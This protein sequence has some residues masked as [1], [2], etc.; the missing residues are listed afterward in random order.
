M[1]IT[2]KS[3]SVLLLAFLSICGRAQ[4][5]VMKAIVLIN[6]DAFLVDVL[7]NGDITT[8]YQEVKNYFKSGES[9]ESMMRRLVPGA[10]SKEGNLVF[11]EK[12]AEPVPSFTKENKRKIVTGNQQYIGFSP[13]KALLLK[14]AVDQIRKI[15]EAYTSSSIQVI[16]ISSY[17]DNSYRTK[18]LARNRAKAIKDLLVAFGVKPSAI[19]TSEFAGGKDTKIDFVQLQFDK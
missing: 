11:Y 3:L 19:G 16:D 15:A 14:P 9:H 13:N 1:L 5:D 4:D 7:E 2:T 8:I 10:R 12:E 17:H 6:G 18:A